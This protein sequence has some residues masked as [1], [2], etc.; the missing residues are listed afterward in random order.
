MKQRRHFLKSLGL[1]LT[2]APLHG[3]TGASILPTNTKRTLKVGVLVPKQQGIIA[4]SDDFVLGLQLALQ[5]E[6]RPI[7]KADCNLYIEQI[8]TAFHKAEQKTTQLLQNYQPD[9]FIALVS[10]MHLPTLTKILDEAQTP[11]LL[12]T[13][14]GNAMEKTMYSPYVYYNSLNHW[15]SNWMLGKQVA[16]AIGQQI[17]VLGSAYD[18]GYD[19]LYAFKKG[20]VDAGGHIKETIITE[21]TNNTIGE[22]TIALEKMASQSLSGVYVSYSGEDVISFAQAYQHFSLRK[23]LPI[24]T[25]DFMIQQLL[26]LG[27]GHLCEGMSS[28]ST[29]TKTVANAANHH[30]IKQY[31]T[32]YQ[33]K[34]NSF[35]MLGYESGLCLQQSL[36]KT[37]NQPTSKWGG[38]MRQ[39]SFDSPRGKFSIN[40]KTHQ[41]NTT[42]YSYQ[43]PK[44]QK[45]NDVI[46]V[47]ATG[48]QTASIPPLFT[49]GNLRTGI[50]TLYLC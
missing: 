28:V 21:R 20:V 42:F 5:K 25:H 39:L 46:P 13:V 9:L 38:A 27:Y 12:N 3:V 35:A 32:T 7:S 50:N 26:A 18:S 14:E 15:Q 34:P 6:Q 2:I 44:N 4:Y 41:N 48:Q 37:N 43:V 31:T 8:P 23:K 30:F 40:P 19:A 16:Q 24:M 22:I 11:A 45:A 36:L 33:Q 10:S 29:W 47:Q 1:G 49:L 17:G